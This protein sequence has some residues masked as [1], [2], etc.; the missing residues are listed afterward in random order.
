VVTLAPSLPYLQMWNPVDIN[1]LP[2][3]PD[4]I[5]AKSAIEQVKT[6]LQAARLAQ[7]QFRIC[8]LKNDLQERRA[9]IAPI[10]RLN[11]DILSLI[12]EF[13][14]ETHWKAPLRI[15][16]V[17]RYWRDIVLA[18]PRAWAFLELKRLG[19]EIYR[20]NEEFEFLRRSGQH[21]LHV[22]LPSYY[23]STFLSG[24]K[25][26]V[27]CL[28]VRHFKTSLPDEVFSRLERLRI[29]SKNSP[30]DLSQFSAT[31]FPSLYDFECAALIIP[32][33][34]R[35]KTHAFPPLRSLSIT[36]T[37]H[38]EWMELLDGCKESLI[39]LKLRVWDSDVVKKHRMLLPALKS[40]EIRYSLTDPGFWPFDFKTPVLAVY[41]ERSTGTRINKTHH[42]DTRNVTHLLLDRTPTLSRFPLLGYLRIPTTRMFLDVLSQLLS[43]QSLCP[44][45]AVLELTEFAYIPD[46]ENLEKMKSCRSFPIRVV[47]TKTCAHLPFAIVGFP[48]RSPVLSLRHSLTVIAVR[49]G[50]AM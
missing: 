50:H 1:A 6:E 4:L 12:F 15:A 21:L 26:R 30:L 9:W 27:K 3:T 5:N 11:F 24:I 47:Y 44:H 40:L 32:T 45:L 31:R 36:L 49:R 28:T 46:K 48:V 14:G 34:D 22:F 16:S 7:D 39:S 38:S 37:D 33:R 25:D 8:H 20:G 17:S 2:T 43:D 41:S 35:P 29:R 10:R 18:T 23:P 13:C 19:K 42:E